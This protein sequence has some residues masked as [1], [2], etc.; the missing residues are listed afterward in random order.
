MLGNRSRKSDINSDTGQL[1]PYRD[2]STRYDLRQPLEFLTWLDDAHT[3]LARLSQ[4][5]LDTW[6]NN[7]RPTQRRPVRAFLQW[8]TRAHLAPRLR[9]PPVPIYEAEPLTQHERIAWLRRILQDEKIDQL[10]RVAVALLLLYAQ[11]LERITRLTVQDFSHDDK[12]GLTIRLGTPPAPVPAPFDELITAYL[13][14][15]RQPTLANQ[16]SD[17]LFPGRHGTLP[18]H[19]TALR[20]RLNELGLRPGA[21]RGGSWRDLVTAAPPAIIADLL[22]YQAP[23]AERTAKA[24]GSTWARYASPR[25]SS[26]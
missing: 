2:Q 6:A 5:R 24:A 8:A 7:A 26:I 20:R 13:Q 1:H 11:P 22:G 17:L 21:A 15:G 9:L 10:E 19:V 3:T 14:D 25:S 18:L 12:G 16:S 23:T 4:P